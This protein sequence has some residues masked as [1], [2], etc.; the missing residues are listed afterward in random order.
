MDLKALYDKPPWEWPEGADKVILGAL[1]DDGADKSDRILA[2]ALAGNSVIVNDELVD[3]LLSIL[4]NG[5][6]PENLRDQAAISL[7]PALELEY[8]DIDGFE[9]PDAVPITKQTFRKIQEALRK[10]YADTGVPKNV[11]HRFWR[12]QCAPRRPGTRMPFVRRISATTR[13]GS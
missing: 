3:V 13:T 11:R 5:G 1:R 8:A 7:G 12:L 6:V 10:L 9:E 4:R 2:A